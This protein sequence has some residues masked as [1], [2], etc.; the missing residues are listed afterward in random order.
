M[1]EADG[2]KLAN[3][4][5]TPVRRSVPGL[6]AAVVQADRVVWTGAAGLADVAS[7][8]P[9]RPQ[10]VYLWFSMTKIV[11]A[12]AVLQLAEIGALGLDDPVAEYVPEF[13]RT[14]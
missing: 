1:Q 2:D 9:A 14:D 4:L 11:T 5:A 10:T 3:A 13:P 7:M 12:T 6:S 8:T